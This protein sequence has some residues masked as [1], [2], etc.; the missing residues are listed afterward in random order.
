MLQKKRRLDDAA[1]CKDLRDYLEG[2][3]LLDAI[4]EHE[5]AE[6]VEKMVQ[7]GLTMMMITDQDFQPD[8]D[9]LANDLGVT[10]KLWRTSILAK[11]KRLNDN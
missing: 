11:W 4:P 1:S 10:K 8:D 5:R 3:G 7:G 6:V 2:V 9:L